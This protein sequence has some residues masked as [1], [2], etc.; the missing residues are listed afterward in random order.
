[1][2]YSSKKCGTELYHGGGGK[3]GIGVGRLDGYSACLP[4]FSLAVKK[5]S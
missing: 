4:M 2:W 3:I 1:M 5:K